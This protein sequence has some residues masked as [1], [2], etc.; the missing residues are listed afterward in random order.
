[1]TRNSSRKKQALY[2]IFAVLCVACFA[3]CVYFI[4]NPLAIK[5]ITKGENDIE[6]DFIMFTDVGQADSA[7]IYSNGYSAV[8]DMGLPNS[9]SEIFE[10]LSSCK[11]KEIDVALISHLHSDHVG[12]LKK[13][14]E[15]YTVKNLIMP[16]ILNS[17]LTAAKN[18]RT[19]ITNNGGNFYNAVAGLNFKIG[20]FEITVLGYLND[21]RNENNRSVFTI[22]EIKGF[23]FL[24]AGDAET[25]AENYILEENLNLDCDVLKVGHHGSNSSTSKEFLRA[26]TPEYAV[27]SV[28]EDNMYSHPN[29]ET[30]TALE[31]ANSKIFRTDKHGDIT[32][33][34]TNEKLE[35][36]TEK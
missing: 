35:I 12:A 34:V 9:A 19:F 32:F 14:S 18:A 27:I 8:I 7:I 13:I 26:T 23:K 11:I 20:E 22:A 30:L 15:I 33:D 10:D 24:F 6:R 17:S 3:I 31:N 4:L 25:K 2:I 29:K 16:E 36:K 5:K 1:M 21:K 28:G